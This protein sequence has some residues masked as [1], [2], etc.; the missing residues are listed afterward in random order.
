MWG[1]KFFN[2]LLISAAI[3]LAQ[4]AYTAGAVQDS[5][6][7]ELN[8][9][10]KTGDEGSFEKHAFSFLKSYPESSYVPEVRMMLAE[11]ESDTELAVERYR[12]VVK[13]FP[14]YEHRDLALFKLCQILDLRSKWKELRDESAQG[15]RLFNSTVYGVEFRLMHINSLIMLEDYEKARSETLAITE[16]THDFEI[17]SRS[18]FLLSEIDK[19]TSGNSKSYIYSLRELAQGFSKSELYPSTLYRLGEFYEQKKDADRAYSVYSDII[20]LYPDSPESEIAITKIDKLKKFNPKKVEYI[21]DMNT[22]N[23]SDKLDISPEYDAADAEEEIYYSVSVG[24]FTK[25][26]DA[27]S[28]SRLLKN[29][30]AKRNVK[31]GAGYYIYIGK[32]TDSD[33][34]FQ[35]RIRL[36]EEYGINGNIVRFSEQ[37]SR[38]YIYGD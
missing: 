3:L 12:S 25:K 15:I 28:M 6:F 10:F 9:I 2:I 29:Y 21:P 35:N 18:I 26:T 8:E 27:D 16:K 17:L 24:P 30:P 31:T 22:V 36:A 13:N 20:K 7:R 11:I 4:A 19:R 23:S 38:S 33:R 1:K 32:F 5:A 14:S 34:A 37:G